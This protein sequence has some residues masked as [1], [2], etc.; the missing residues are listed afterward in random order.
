MSFPG[1]S[2]CLQRKQFSR[3]PQAEEKF[4]RVFPLEK[5]L[6]DE[7][8]VGEEGFEGGFIMLPLLII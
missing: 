2:F 1:K 7:G 5:T 4:D 3:N 8:V 6:G